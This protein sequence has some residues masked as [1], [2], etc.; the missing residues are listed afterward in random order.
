MSM[1][2]HALILILGLATSA[3]A[4]LSVVL[5]R[6]RSE[7][8]RQLMRLQRRR[9]QHVLLRLRQRATARDVRKDYWGHFYD[10]A[11]PVLLTTPD[12]SIVAANQALLN[13]LGYADEAD[14]KRVNAVKLYANPRAR[15][16]LRVALNADGAIH[17]V[18]AKFKRKDGVELDVLISSR[19][20]ALEKGQLL[21]EGVCTDISELRQAAAQA[22]KLEAE[23]HLSRKLQA[24]GQLASGIAHEINTP[25]QFIGDNVHYLRSTFSKV[26]ATWR[27]MRELVQARVTFPAIADLAREIEQLEK[28][29]KLARLM[30]DA[31]LAIV[32]SMEGLERVTET[33]RAMK[34][35][36][37]PDD[38]EMS[39]V[40]LNQSIR[41]TLI[42]A[43][44]EYKQVAE[45]I[46]EFGDL[47]AVTCRPGAMN[48]VFLNLI[49]NAAHAI[50]RKMADGGGR[51]VIT[52]RTVGDSS[53]IE[54][55]I[56]DTG[57]GI[58]TTI[59]TRI[60]DPFF[61]TKPVGKGTGQGLAIARS[62]VKSHGGQIE[63]ESAPGVGTTFKIRL[64]RTDSIGEAD[65][66]GDPAP[67]VAVNSS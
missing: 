61:T 48:K 34:E 27:R 33:V 31:E 67:G 28:E 55:A 29:V 44:N 51:G 26:A 43:R 35:F 6:Q 3:L 7:L 53:G 60:F 41:T 47:P 52:V 57:C 4:V 65:A 49:V 62:I 39:A 58:P 54:V 15:D 50:E 40:D 18:E 9:R 20:V 46:T 24:V 56:S 8:A 23:L 64:P 13:L 17:N 66:L 1:A 36:A 5:L 38:G 2:L 11:A 22:L 12:G 25:I 10:V 19:I 59:I 37:H 42:V 63:V 21:F 30:P 14:I 16:S 32:E 45:I